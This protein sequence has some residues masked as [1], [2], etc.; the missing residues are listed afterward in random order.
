M[1]LKFFT[2]SCLMIAA[3]ALGYQVFSSS[4]QNQE[5]VSLFTSTMVLMSVGFNLVRRELAKLRP[6]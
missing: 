6:N 2:W 3:I 1:R 5:A 4:G